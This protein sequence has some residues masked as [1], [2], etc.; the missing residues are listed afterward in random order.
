MVDWCNP[1]L[2]CTSS[3]HSAITYAVTN[4]IQ[5]GWQ[6]HSKWDGEDT[7]TLEQFLDTQ[8]A[9]STV[10]KPAT[11]DISQDRCS[12]FLKTSSS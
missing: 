10:R 8:I 7:C 3:V 9:E 2:Y 5:R 4:L 1:A 12:R 6:H 11:L